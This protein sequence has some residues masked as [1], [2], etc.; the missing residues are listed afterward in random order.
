[1]TCLTQSRSYYHHI[2]SFGCDPS[3]EDPYSSSFSYPY[4]YYCHCRCC[5][6]WEIFTFLLIKDFFEN[7]K[8]RLDILC[9]VCY[10]Q[11]RKGGEKPM[12]KKKKKAPKQRLEVVKTILEIVAIILGIVSTIIT[13]L[14][15]WGPGG[16]KPPL[17][18]QIITHRKQMRNKNIITIIALIVTFAASVVNGVVNGFGW[19][20]IVTIIAAVAALA[21]NV[22]LSRNRR[23]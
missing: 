5:C 21:S 2:Q 10:N 13:L 20:N 18:T 3:T 1:M 17:L 7:L 14:K 15:G 19:L 8:K 12:G 23:S 9:R 6:F 4:P 16:G 11:A 22:V